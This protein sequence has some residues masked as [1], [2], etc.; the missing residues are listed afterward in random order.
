MT[1]N[2]NTNTESQSS[3]QTE[4]SE[5]MIPKSRLN[6]EIKKNKE[7]AARLEALEN[8]AKERDEASRK[9]RE[10]ELTEQNR[11]KELYEAAQAELASLKSAQDEAKRYRESFENTLKARIESIPEDKRDLIPDLDPIAKMAWLDKAMPVL[12]APMKPTAPRLDGGSGGTGSSDGT[13]KPLNA[14]Q[15]QLADL[16][17]QSGFN[18]DV[19]RIAQF[20]RNPTTQT[21]LSKKDES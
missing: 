19:N 8:T 10:T 3:S 2:P 4:N 12:V 14:T 6:E 11:Y 7:L 13:G 17:R 1:E 5:R 16:A 20:N 15:M 18:V 21:D 9:Q